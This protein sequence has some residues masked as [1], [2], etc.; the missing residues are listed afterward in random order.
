[1]DDQRLLESTVLWSEEDRQH[2]T[3]AGEVLADQVE[4]ML[5]LRY[6]FVGSHGHLR[7]LLQRSRRR[8]R[9]PL[10]RSVRV[11]QWVRAAIAS[12]APGHVAAVRDLF[13]DR[14]VPT[15]LEA[16]AQAAAAV[17]AGIDDDALD[18]GQRPAR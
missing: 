8:A 3:L 11:P 10:P 15:Q 7:A 2:L 9:Q 12:A 17:L 4:A 13:I 5:D 1:M 6:G 16:I 18:D 14:L